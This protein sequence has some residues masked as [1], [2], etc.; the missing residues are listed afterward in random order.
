MIFDDPLV[1]FLNANHCSCRDIDRIVI[2]VKVI[3]MGHEIVPSRK[4][5]TIN[6]LRFVF[7]NSRLVECIVYVQIFSCLSL[8][9]PSYLMILWFLIKDV[10]CELGQK[11][12]YRY[13]PHCSC[14][15]IAITCFGFARAA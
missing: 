2:N 8:K 12:S 6:V 7:D 10:V 5:A 9:S 3:D 4:E 1:W 15:L 11:V 13:N 14:L